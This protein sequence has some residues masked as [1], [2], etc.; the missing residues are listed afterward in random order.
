MI[1]Y[2]F[3]KMV[4]LSIVFVICDCYIL[5]IIWMNYNG[6]YVNYKYNNFNYFDT[7]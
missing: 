1:K 5:H 7:V 3:I 4:W 2:I 6:I